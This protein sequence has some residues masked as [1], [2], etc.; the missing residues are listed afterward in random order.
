MWLVSIRTPS[1]DASVKCITARLVRR[2]PTGGSFAGDVAPEL[3]DVMRA[4]VHACNDASLPMSWGPQNAWAGGADGTHRSRNGCG[5]TFLRGPNAYVVRR[6]VVDDRHVTLCMR[7]HARCSLC[8]PLHTRVNEH[9]QKCGEFR[10]LHALSLGVDVTLLI[11]LSRCGDI[12]WINIFLLVD[13]H[14]TWE[15]ESFYLL[16]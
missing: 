10:V 11:V 7:M 6:P 16:I 4:W 9:T 14:D 13:E 2:W 8:L 5:N 15:R 3:P 12:I 1:P